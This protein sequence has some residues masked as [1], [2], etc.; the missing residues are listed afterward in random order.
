[1]RATA[2]GLKI[3]IEIVHL[4]YF[5]HKGTGVQVSGCRKTI[6]TWCLCLSRNSYRLA[7][8]KKSNA[9]HAKAINRNTTFFKQVQTFK[10]PRFAEGEPRLI[11]RLGFSLKSI[12]FHLKLAFSKQME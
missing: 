1:M 11:N 10:R 7:L 4:E 3:H 6:R 8:N 9:F 12:I 5:T 2:W